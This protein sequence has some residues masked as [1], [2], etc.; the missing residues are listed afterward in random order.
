MGK[1][2]EEAEREE[3]PSGVVGLRNLG[4]RTA[5]TMSAMC[6]C[7]PNSLAELMLLMRLLL[8]LLLLLLSPYLVP[9]SSVL[10]ASCRDYV[11]LLVSCQQ[12]MSSRRT[13]MTSSFN[14]DTHMV[15]RTPVFICVTTQ[16]EPHVV[17]GRYA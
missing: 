7:P 5:E 10:I 1:T 12:S 14:F 2:L 17:P 9:Q 3:M 13:C 15:V 11:N 8:L 6:L 16:Y 4:K